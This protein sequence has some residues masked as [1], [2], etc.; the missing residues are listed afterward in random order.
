MQY[1]QFVGQ[2]QHRAQLAKSDQA[3][4]AIRATLNTL[5]DRLYGGEA[6]NLASQLPFEIG[7]Y[8]EEGILSEDFGMDEFFER[9]SLREGVELP[10]AIHHAR[11]VMDVLREA[12][13]PELLSKVRDQLPREY[14]QL[15]TPASYRKAA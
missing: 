10:D 9:A 7:R 12:V 13:S 14:D 2:V 15:F 6:H 1:D 4:A 5:G 3:V 8:L 11:V